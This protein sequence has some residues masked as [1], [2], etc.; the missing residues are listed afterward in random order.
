M[1]IKEHKNRI[2]HVKPIKMTND[3]KIEGIHSPLADMYSF[4]YL[5]IGKPNSGKTC[6]WLSLLNEPSDNTYWEKFDQ[7]HIFSKSLKTI[8]TEIYLTEDRLHDGID[9]LEAVLDDIKDTDDR[10]LL[11]F[12]DVVT[13]IK[14]TELM[15]C[16]IYNRRHA[17]A[18]GISI[19]MISQVYNKIPLCLRKCAS[20]LIL[21]STTNKRELF[22]IYDDYINL[23]KNNWLKLCKYVFRNAHDFLFINTN[24]NIYYRNF[25]LL[26]ITE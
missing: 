15:Q 7:V 9:D 13:D 23:E 1:N 17:W 5:I 11:I 6:L 14:E 18:A 20:H 25:N 10:V 19:I 24:D 26:T 12:D 22:S 4:Y 2:Y 16:L 21:F 8:S 3:Q